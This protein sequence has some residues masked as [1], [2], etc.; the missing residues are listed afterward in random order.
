MSALAKAGPVTAAM[1]MMMVT[2]TPGSCVTNQVS[3]GRPKITVFTNVTIID[4]TGK[5]AIENGALIVSGDKI[6]SVSAKSPVIPK[7]AEVID[8]KGM[9]IM[10]A[11]VDAHTHLGLLNGPSAL[12]N[13]Q[14]EAN[15]IRQLKRFGRYGIGTVLSLGTDKDFIYDLRARQQR[16]ELQD[17]PEILTAGHGF[18]IVG[19][20]PPIEG[21]IDDLA[22]RPDTPEDARKNI[23]ELASH[24]A[25]MV[26]MWLDDLEGTVA[27]MKP[28]IYEAIINEAHKKGLK[29]SAH[30]FHLAD[31]KK[32][33]NADVDILAHSIRDLPAD[34][35]LASAMK[36]HGTALVPTMDL[37]EV[38]FIYKDSGVLNDCLKNKFFTDALDHGMAEFL[39]SDDYKLHPHER[40][41]LEVAKNN[42]K[43]LHDKGVKIGFGT[44]TGASPERI[45]GYGEHRELQLMVEAGLTP[46]EAIHC[47]TGACAEMLG[48][49]GKTGTLAPGKRADFIVLKA[50]PLADIKNTQQISDVWLNGKKVPAGQ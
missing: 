10:P 20:A 27:T 19:G 39:G 13:N 32:L 46:M 29:V 43:F 44:D 23:D 48:I 14:D 9:T 42:L 36:A 18:G 50:D 22:Y 31:A 7:G 37:D 15:D 49:A 38:C 21:K 3:T 30:I 11:L 1:L 2:Q 35:E 26:K 34:D 17:C 16:G 25:N 40:Q 4:G 5:P 6:K 24:K 47:A 12:T 41:A 45:Q 8:A 33:V 28:E